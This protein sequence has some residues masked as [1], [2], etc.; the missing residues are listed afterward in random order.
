MTR[1]SLGDHLA[2]LGEQSAAPPKGARIEDEG[3]TLALETGPREAEP[4]DEQW[5]SL[6]AEWGYDWDDYEVD[7]TKPM[8]VG[9]HEGF[10]KTKDPNGAAG[11]FIDRKVKLRNFKVFLRRR[12]GDRVDVDELCKLALRR[13]PPKRK[14]APVTDAVFVVLLSDY[15]L[16][17]SEGT[18]T[19]LDGDVVTGT[20]AT[21]HRIQDAFSLK[22]AR[23]RQTKPRTVALVGLG[24]QVEACFGHYSNQ[25]FRTDLHERDQN[26]VATRLDMWMI[27]QL[28]D[29]GVEQIVVSKVPSNHGEKRVGKQATQTDPLRDN[30]DLELGDR[31]AEICH[32]NPDR[33]GHVRV[34]MP[35][36]LH[37]E[38]CAIELDGLRLATHHGHWHRRGKAMGGTHRMA[39]ALEWW[40]ENYFNTRGAADADMLVF[41]HGHHLLVDESTMRPAIQAPAMDGGSEWFSCNTGTES[42]HGM[43]SFLFGA[44]LGTQRPYADLQL[45]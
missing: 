19:T 42:P 27:D 32:H 24:D 5:R 44:S 9:G 20:E 10:Y 7:P 30:R 31:I 45:D 6:L 39:T 35:S 3:N 26:R 34:V 16:G 11:E 21:V 33:Y 38:V 17:K 28:V 36:D 25:G 40:K 23:I 43:V 12:I 41:G 15:Q 1:P 37:P 14:L 2:V 13:K 4:T 8:K 29:L 22:L 18:Y